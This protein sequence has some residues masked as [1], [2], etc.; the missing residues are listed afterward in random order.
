MA[1]PAAIIGVVLVAS[2][3]SDKRGVERN[4]ARVHAVGQVTRDSGS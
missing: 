4:P 2:A 1:V 3:F